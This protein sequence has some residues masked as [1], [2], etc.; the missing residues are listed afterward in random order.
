MGSSYV[1]L[2]LKLWCVLSSIPTHTVLTKVWW[3]GAP[4]GKNYKNKNC[5]RHLTQGECVLQR[6]QTR[7]WRLQF[8]CRA[9][10]EKGLL[11]AVSHGFHPSPFLPPWL[12]TSC[13]LRLA[14]EELFVEWWAS[15]PHPTILTEA[16]T[17]TNCYSRLRDM[18]NQIN[19]QRGG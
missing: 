16:W 18:H 3:T 19:T 12:M 7:W 10:A 17:L 13:G 5:L 14:N 2:D 6:F 4:A 9:A 15:S 1:L 11:D 8:N